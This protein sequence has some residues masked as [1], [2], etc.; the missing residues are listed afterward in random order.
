MPYS[1][2][3]INSAGIYSN[4]ADFLIY[5]ALIAASASSCRTGRDS[6]FGICVLSSTARSQSV[7]S[8]FMSKQY[9]VHLLRSPWMARPRLVLYG[10]RLY[11]VFSV[12]GSLANRYTFFL[13]TFLKIA[14]TDWQ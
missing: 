11:S 5:S 9:S 13:M 12:V 14:S 8:L 4:P 10:I 2:A 1:P 7:L 6:P 3:L